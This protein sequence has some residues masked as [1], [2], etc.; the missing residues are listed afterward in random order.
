MAGKTI[1]DIGKYLQSHGLNIGEHPMFGGVGGGHSPTGYHPRGEAI[2]VR[3]WRPDIAPAYPGG[4]P[5][6]WKTRT[7]E[8]KWRANQLKQLG[9]F[10][11]VLGP[12]DPG[13]D[14]HV[15]LALSGSQPI[16]EQQ[17]EWLVTGRVK[18]PE[19]LSDV[20]PGAQQ[21]TQQAQPQKTNGITEEE[22]LRDYM[23][24][25]LKY[26]MLAQML[27]PQKQNTIAEFQNMMGL[28]GQG[29]MANPLG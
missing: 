1:V 25:Q 28:V 19:G 8:L 5:K 3:D 17:M 16:S 20:M 13:H 24:Q 21:Q 11:E 27:Q 12:G 9:L 2:D 4:Q 6:D 22:F 26:G 14:T 23:E 15:H 29:A 10:N 7:G 18:T